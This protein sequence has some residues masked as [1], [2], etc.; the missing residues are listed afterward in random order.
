MAISLCTHRGNYSDRVLRQKY[1]RE[2]SKELFRKSIHLCGAFIPFF[3]EKFYWP[4]ICLL[5]L[6]LVIYTFCEILRLKGKKVPLIS[7]ITDIASRKRDENT[8]VIG[9]VTLVF[10]IIFTA[11]IFDPL[12]AKIGILALALGDGL[13]S[14]SGKFFGHVFVPFTGGKTVA[15]SLACFIAI[16]LSSY[17]CW[18]MPLNS[19]ILGFF[20]MFVEILPLKNF[21]NVILPILVAFVATM[22]L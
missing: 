19:I 3:L 22:L 6:A 11:L 9:P 2:I 5:I 7:K 15:G 4:V 17:F 10:G 20:G 12:P 8:F 13:A 21:D 18:K 1:K 16:F 14:L